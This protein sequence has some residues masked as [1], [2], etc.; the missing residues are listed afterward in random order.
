M[1][2]PSDFQDG[3]LLTAARFKE[4]T[5]ALKDNIGGGA[6]TQEVPSGDKN[7]SNKTF[8][9]SA[10]PAAVYFNGI[11]MQEEEDYTVSESSITFTAN[12]PAPVSTDRIW[13]LV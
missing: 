8:T 12:Q 11:A 2:W 3:E 4:W 9:F 13:G 7:G 6:L 10:A 5:D 1:E